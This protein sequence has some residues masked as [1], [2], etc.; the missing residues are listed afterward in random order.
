[1]DLLDSPVLP[2]DHRIAYGPAPQQFGDLWLPAASSPQKKSPVVAFFHGGWWQ[3]QYDLGY[4]G[5]LCR[6]LTQH[7]IAVWS[8]EYRRVGDPN[9]GWPGTFLDAAAALN[10]LPT[11]ARTYPIDAT[12]VITM[13]H[14][15]GGHLAFWL[16]GLHHVDAHS[17]IF[18]PATVPLRG[19]IALAGAVDLRLTID[20]SGFFTFAHDKQEVYSLLDGTPSTQP[21]R[22]RQANP[23]DLLPFNIPQILIQGKDDTQIPPT[24]PTRWAALA[25]RMGDTVSTSILPHLDHFDVVDP[26]TPAF[27][28]IL[29]ATQ[30]LLSS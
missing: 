13:G 27:A 20:L 6:A 12:R 14:S 15:A 11:L 7:G 8:A 4:A 19:T 1:M 26:T 2:P 9:G 3:S 21:E 10:F 18:T 29:A 28:T 22:Y 17:P 16:A 30:S 5:Y 23:G 25:H 24:L